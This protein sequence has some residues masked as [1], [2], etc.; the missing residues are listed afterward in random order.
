MNWCKLTV[1]RFKAFLAL[2]EEAIAAVEFA[3]IT[4]FLLLL[5]MG[6]LEVSQIIAVDRKMAAATGALGDLV[7]RNN[8]S[9]SNATLSDYFSAVGLIMTPYSADNLKQLVTVVF[10][11]EDGDTSVEWSVAHNGATAKTEGNE[12]ILPAEI[13]DIATN[14]YVIVAEAEIP[15][16]PWG[17]YVVESTITLYRQYFHLPRFGALI[18]LT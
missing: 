11:D 15:Y 6:S 14:T 17:G 5:Y 9:L 18:E 10:V 12:Y 1:S 8:G 3:L 7:A 4:P 13:T 16:Q 2:K